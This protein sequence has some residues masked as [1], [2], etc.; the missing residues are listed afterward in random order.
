MHQHV[1]LARR[2]LLDDQPNAF[3]PLRRLSKLLPGGRR[4]ERDI[5]AGHAR[6]DAII[7]ATVRRF[8]PIMLTAMTAV[9]AMVPLSRSDF[10]GPM[11]VAI[12]GGLLVGT[13][14]TLVV[15]PSM[16]AVWFRVDE[17]AP[18]AGAGAD[19]ISP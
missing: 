10:Y 5:A 17:H 3:K 16:Y 12:M 19:T 8:R 4:G 14:L 11:A 9:L 7:D 18:P 6:W 13:V 2:N 15:L 1:S